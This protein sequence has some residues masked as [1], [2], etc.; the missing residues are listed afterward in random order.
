MYRLD[1]ADR[2]DESV[3]DEVTG[4]RRAA[5]VRPTPHAPQLLEPNGAHELAKSGGLT[6][7]LGKVPPQDVVHHV[8]AALELLDDPRSP[9]SV[10][11]NDAR[12]EYEL[13]RWQIVDGRQGT[14]APARI[15]QRLDH[16]LWGLRPDAAPLEMSIPALDCPGPVTLR[17]P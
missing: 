10:A 11:E 14:G 9:I 3:A 8:R 5:F 1:P 7:R 13:I 16:E 15:S 17:Q 12:V 2:A 6:E 4:S